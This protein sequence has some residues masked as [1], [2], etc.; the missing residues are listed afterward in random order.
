MRVLIANFAAWGNCGDEAI[1]QAIMDEL[2]EN[3]YSVSTTLPFIML[4]DYHRRFPSLRDVRQIY[5][6]RT[7]FDAYILGG[8]KLG[9]GYGWRQA[10]AVF[11]ADLPA[12]NYGVAYD[13]DPFLYHPKLNGLYAD[14]LKQF[15]A[16]TVRDQESFNIMEEIGVKSTLTM[17]PAINL[18]EEKISCPENMIAVC[19]RFEDADRMG[20]AGDNKPQVD[21]IVK[22]LEGL[23]EE[24][25]LIPFAPKNM[26]GV[27]VDLEL[28]REIASKVKGATILPTDGYNPKQVKYA[29]SKSRIVISGGRYHAVLWA[30][31]HNKPFEVCPTT[32]VNYPRIKALI[33]TYSKYGDKLKDM[34]KKNVEIFKKIVNGDRN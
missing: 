32:L 9:W 25:L 11:S 10:L 2:G 19:P 18:K 17:C 29:I 21:W 33:D 4:S 1:L 24:V 7:D 8:G 15:N 14:F 31:V 28:C 3:E 26:E 23:G 22:R 27:P 30:I 6:I 34:E 20:N 16:I 12:M 13:K 5:D